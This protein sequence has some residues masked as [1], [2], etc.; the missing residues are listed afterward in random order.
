[1]NFFFHLLPFKLNS[2]STINP[3]EFEVYHLFAIVITQ[4]VLDIKEH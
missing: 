4:F 2:N 3:A 1:M